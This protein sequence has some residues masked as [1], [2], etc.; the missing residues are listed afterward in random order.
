MSDL[1]TPLSRQAIAEDEAW[2]AE[3]RALITSDADR[4]S[5]EE[6]IA[7]AERDVAKMRRHLRRIS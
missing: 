6:S 5:I 7:R 3:A 4:S 1:S 2:I